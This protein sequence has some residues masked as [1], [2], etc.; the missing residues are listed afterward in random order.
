[1]KPDDI[2]LNLEFISIYLRTCFFVHIKINNVEYSVQ[3][4]YSNAYTI[5]YVRLLIIQ[6]N[7]KYY[8]R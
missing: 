8:L 4:P 7:S 6:G 2:S 5:N 3:I 1:M